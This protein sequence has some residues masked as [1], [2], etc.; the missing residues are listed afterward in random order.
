[1]TQILSLLVMLINSQASQIRSMRHVYMSFDGTRGKEKLFY[2]GH[3]M[4]KPIESEVCREKSKV[5]M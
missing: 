1:M 5:R 4:E 3:H 2:W